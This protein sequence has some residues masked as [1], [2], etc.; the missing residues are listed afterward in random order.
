ME[1]NFNVEY[2][3]VSRKNPELCAEF[4]NLGY[5]Y[6]K[7]VAS[8]WST[9]MHNKFLNS[10]LN[11]Q[12]E[13]ERW[14]IGLKINDSMV[15]FSHFKIDRSERIGWGYIME[16]YIMPDFRRKGLGRKLYSLIRE[17]FAT[18]EIKDI[19]LT[20]NKVNGEPFWF[21]LGFLDSGET[22]H[23]MKILTISI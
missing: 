13:D 23:E 14:L 22:E 20:A 16:F 15:G 11:H 9:E 8:D 4:L 2:V 12:T 7:E 1:N 19:W 6:M 3:R 18:Y 5:E 17:E 10:I 21:S